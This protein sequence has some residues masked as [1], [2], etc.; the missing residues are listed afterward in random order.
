[1]S[2]VSARRR[3]GRVGVLVEAGADLPGAAVG[4]LD[5]DMFLAGGERGAQPGLLAVAEVLVTRA[6]MFL[7]Q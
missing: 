5:L 6:E 7:T 3:P 1:M 2:T 4:D